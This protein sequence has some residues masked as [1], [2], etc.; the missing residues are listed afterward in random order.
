[1]PRRNVVLT[2]PQSQI[3]D[4]LVAAGRYQ[5]AS[6]ALRAELQL[7]EREEAGLKSC[8]HGS[9]KVCRTRGT[10]SLPKVEVK[11]GRRG[12]FQVS[13]RSAAGLSAMSTS[14]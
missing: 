10:A 5:N 11:L 6:E 7:L 3:N 2:E 1:M 9:L 8:E 12:A 14:A 4:N 13:K